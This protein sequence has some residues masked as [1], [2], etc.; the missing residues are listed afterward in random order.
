[1]PRRV[2]FIPPE[3]VS[4]TNPPRES[5]AASTTDE[6]EFASP[7]AQDARLHIVPVSPLDPP[8]PVSDVDGLAESTESILQRLVVSDLDSNRHGS[9]LTG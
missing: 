6:F 8:S 9:R 4:K 5:E 2:I 7:T 1:V 3:Q